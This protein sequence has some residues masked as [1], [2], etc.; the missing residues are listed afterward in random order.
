MSFLEL[1]LVESC[2][3]GD[4]CGFPKTGQ[5]E[6][7]IMFYF[8]SSNQW[9]FC[10]HFIVPLSRTYV[11]VC[12]VP[13]ERANS[14][15]PL[16]SWPLYVMPACNPLNLARFYF[17]PIFLS[18]WKPFSTTLENYKFMITKL[19]LIWMN[20]INSKKI[21]MQKTKKHFVHIPFN[22]FRFSFF[23]S[24]C[25]FVCFVCFDPL[26]SFGFN[27]IFQQFPIV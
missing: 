27:C 12:L 20:R 10:D 17:T 23:V 26:S 22:L 24:F 7:D 13:S 25:L 14:S 21:D 18:S 3:L 8:C 11:I 4:I 15:A 19:P 1:G 5:A 16:F 6:I 2:R 9:D